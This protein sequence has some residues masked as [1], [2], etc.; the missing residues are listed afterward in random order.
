MSMR[1]WKNELPFDW[2]SKSLKR[3]MS[4]KVMV[5]QIGV[6]LSSCGQFDHYSF[7]K[8]TSSALCFECYHKSE[9]KPLFT[10]V[11]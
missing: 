10:A 6:V 7:T 3:V 8:E 1:A 11:M 5:L 2:S 4:R 9:E